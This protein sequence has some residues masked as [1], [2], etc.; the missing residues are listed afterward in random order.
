MNHWRLVTISS[1]RSPFSKNLTACVIGRGSPTRSPDSFSCSTRRVRACDAP[2]PTSGA[3]A[4]SARAGSIDGQPSLPNVMRAQRAVGLDD[5]T[6]RQVQLAPPDHVGQVAE[7]A[8]HRD[9]G[10]LLGVGQVMRADRHLDAEQRRHDLGA[11]QRLIPRIVGMGDQRDARRDQLRA[12]R[13]D[14]DVALAIGTRE[15]DPVVRAGHLAVLELGLGDG[16]LEVHV[17]QRGRLE[18][19]GLPLREQPQEGQLR[20]ALGARA[21]GRVGHR[22]VDREPE[23]LPEVLERLLVFLGEAR[24]Q[25]DEVGPRHRDRLL[26]RGGRR[27][28]RRVVR[29]RRIA[30]HAVVVLDAPLGGQP[31][32]VPPHRIA[33]RV[34]THALV[35]GDDVGVGVGEDVPHV[36]RAADGRGRRVDGIDLVARASPVE[37]VHAVG[38]PP[39][40]PL[41]FEA[42]EGRL[43]GNVVG[44]RL[45]GHLGHHPVIVGGAPSARKGARHG[46][47]VVLSAGRP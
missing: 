6:N 27:L 30:A 25:L 37:P 35:A 40:L 36:Q 22:P 47:P 45:A 9:A 34:A 5:R 21:D 44:R 20:N 10:P 4:A 24:A 32:V 14:L 38:L 46:S 31:V 33:H 1:G 28:E 15:P 8:D 7:R 39:G 11:E 3:Y 43:F 13:V 19:V 17:P 16:R 12:R 23:V 2:R 29:Q 42:L 26:A 41:R 18:L